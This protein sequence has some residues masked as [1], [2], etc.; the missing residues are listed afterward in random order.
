MKKYTGT[1]QTLIDLYNSYNTY[2]NKIDALQAE[3]DKL[4]A[5]LGTAP[6]Y[7][8]YVD[9]WNS[10]GQDRKSDVAGY[11]AAL[12]AYQAKQTALTAKAKE[13]GKNKN[14]LPSIDAKIGNR[15]STLQQSD[16][17]VSVN[18]T[19]LGAIDTENTLNQNIQSEI[20]NLLTINKQQAADAAKSVDQVAKSQLSKY[21][22]KAGQAGYIF[23]TTSGTAGALAGTATSEAAMKKESIS[24][25]QEGYTN[26]LTG[27]S[28]SAN[29]AAKTLT[30]AIGKSSNDWIGLSTSSLNTAT[31][32]RL[33][34]V[35][36]YMT[37]NDD[38]GITTLDPTA[39]TTVKNSVT[40]ID[41][42]LGTWDLAS[43][44]KTLDTLTHNSANK[45]TWNQMLLD[46]IN[47]DNP[48]SIYGTPQTTS[49]ASSMTP[50]ATPTTLAE[51]A[52]GTGKN[53]LAAASSVDLTSNVYT[54]PSL[55][56]NDKK[57]A[58]RLI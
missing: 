51:A 15:E 56:S 31:D 48:Y 28:A 14:Y 4:N 47:P 49:K 22:V 8:D 27:K 57:K 12:E 45:Q 46:R 43:Y 58:G 37:T 35:D 16:V 13:I 29:D 41:T 11:T 1:D 21:A 5:D 20:G 19:A 7:S 24:G 42:V 17:N 50:Q 55:L 26:L 40:A 36:T 9:E 30:G 2:Q 10:T 39:D 38:G 32:K 34:N 18:K 53:L 25:Y 52:D 23:D 33:S 54:S 3:W 6:K 44:N